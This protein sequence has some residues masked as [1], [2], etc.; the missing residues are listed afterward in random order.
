MLQGGLDERS[1]PHRIW[2]HLSNP[3]AVVS[4]LEIEGDEVEPVNVFPLVEA[5][6]D[7]RRVPVEEL[8]VAQLLPGRHF[9]VRLE[10]IVLLHGTDFF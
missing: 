2:S 8:G 9:A 3:A 5:G 7:F 4:H 10:E 6:V 1:K